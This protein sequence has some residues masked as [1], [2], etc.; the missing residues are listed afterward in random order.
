MVVT[1]FAKATPGTLEALRSAP[2]WDA[3]GDMFN[4][5]LLPGAK[6][7]G[8]FGW[9]NLTPFETLS[10]PTLL[11]LGSESPHTTMAERLHDTMPNSRLATLEGYG[12]FV[13]LVAPDRYTDEVLSFISDV[14]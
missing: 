2:A 11:L 6:A 8:E 5:N 14:D 12:H 10:T 7:A 3:H 4:Q 13:H 1:D 9:W